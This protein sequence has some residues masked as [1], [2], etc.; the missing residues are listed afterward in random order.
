M[1]GSALIC[2]MA[3]ASAAICFGIQQRG[4]QT[5][6]NREDEAQRQEAELAQLSVEHERLTN[7][8]ARGGGRSES[9][10][11]QQ[12]QELMRLRNEAGRLREVELEKTK[13]ET[14]NARLQTER[15]KQAR[16]LAEAQAAPNY[17]AKE[18]L[19]YAGNGDPESAMK[20]FLW[21]MV[22]GA[23]LNFWRA[24]L[25][26]EAMSEIGRSWDKRGLFEASREAEIQVMAKALTGPSSGFHI[27]EQT[28]TA[29]N[30]AIIRL[31]F[32]G[33]GKTRKF[34]LRNSAE[35][36][37]LQKMIFAWMED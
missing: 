26:P 32:D 4:E 16:K 6:R 31:S 28:M 29:T 10:T 17:W 18:R 33:E 2:L 25:T 27:L 11:E 36:W 12:I 19:A 15:V 5:V 22:N 35:G 7:V 37:K 14:E 8:I 20:S 34:V 24:N 30:E 23:D 1:K 9:I 13:L 21:G 3:I